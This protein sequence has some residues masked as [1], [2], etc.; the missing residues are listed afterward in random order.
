MTDVP[1]GRRKD[2][3]YA[4]ICANHRPEKQDPNR[5]RITLGGNL[6]HYPGDVRT[7]MLTVKLL[8]NSV[9]STPGAKFMSLDISNF[10]LMAPMDRPEFVRMHLSDFPDDVIY[11]YNLK[12]IATADG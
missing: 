5:I 2:I 7:R 6:V 4:R 9:I 8:I 1:P 12:D 11:E 10:Y 3:T